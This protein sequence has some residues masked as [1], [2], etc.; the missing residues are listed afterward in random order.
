MLAAVTTPDA[1]ALTRPPVPLLLLSRPPPSQL[2]TLRTCKPTDYRI[3]KTR[4]APPRP[5]SRP[6]IC[7]LSISSFFPFSPVQPTDLLRSSLNLL[8]SHFFRPHNANQ[9][10]CSPRLHYCFFEAY[11]MFLPLS[12][13]LFCRLRLPKHYGKVRNHLKNAQERESALITRSSRTFNG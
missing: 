2:I 7:P 9:P 10:R 13:S 8:L 1:P 11:A 4:R 5:T 6:Y 3:H 12:G